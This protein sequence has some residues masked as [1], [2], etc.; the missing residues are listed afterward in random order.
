MFAV[1]SH[2]CNF[3]N[4]HFS[5]PPQAHLASQQQKI[6][7]ISQPVNRTDQAR[8]MF[9]ISA[10]DDYENLQELVQVL[11]LPHHLLVIHLDQ[12]TSTEFVNQEHTLCDSY[13]NV[14]V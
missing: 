2:V 7:R 4:Y 13:T 10:F 11:H 6:A 14:V 1:A 8:L 12:S 9:L 5:I 3:S